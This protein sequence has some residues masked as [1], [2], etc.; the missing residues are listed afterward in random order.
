MADPVSAMAVVFAVSTLTGAAGQ[1]YSGYSAD[2]A[3]KKQ[4][5]LIMDQ[6][7]LTQEE[8][9]LEAER[10]ATE[11]RRF[12]KRQRVAFLKSG[13]TLEGSPLLILEET[14]FEGQKEVDAIVKSGNTRATFL[15]REAQITRSEGRAQL[16]GGILGGVSDAGTSFAAGANAGM[17]GSN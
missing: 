3:S 14:L 5:G 11:V 8:A 15:E 13:V 1:I 17:F 7:R 12:E 10:R 6:A 2:K 4:S 9:R 16:I